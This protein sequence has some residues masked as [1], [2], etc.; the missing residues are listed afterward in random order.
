MRR[1][2]AYI[3]TSGW[4]YSHWRNRFYPPGL[5]TR[6]WLQFLSQEFDTV[7]VN[8]SFYRLP[9]AETVARWSAEVPARFRIALKMWRA[10][11]HYKKLVDC[12]HQLQQFFEAANRL[13]SNRR[14]PILVQL[15]PSLGLDLPRLNAFLHDLRRAA[16]AS[17][18]KVAVEFRRNDW[19]V[20]EVYQLLDQ[21]RVAICL[22][23]MHDHGDTEQPNNAR[24]VYIRRH[25]P[26]GD[27]SGS[28][29]DDQ[30]RRDAKRIAAWQDAGRTVFV[31]F[32][33]DAQGHAIRDAR[34]LRGMLADAG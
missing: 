28:Y 12:E 24:F 22:H 4:N 8:S 16:G 7:E 18:W 15:P 27:Y 11:T 17:R 14:G 33:N 32:N 2:R 13:P 19:L 5:P 23:D 1:G 6:Q 20:P 21:R 25:G 3:G 26:H 34:R 10:V 31:Y 30:L 9:R 29:A